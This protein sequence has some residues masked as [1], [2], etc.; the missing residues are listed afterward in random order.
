V[1]H[2]ALMGA[3]AAAAGV[4]TPAVVFAGPVGNG[5]GVLIQEW[6][7]AL[8]I[9]E[10]SIEATVR[11][12]LWDQVDTLHASGMAHGDLQPASI[13]VDRGMHVW[14]VDFS[15]AVAG[16]DEESEAADV[17][18]VRSILAAVPAPM[19]TAAST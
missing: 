16:A 8:P 2:E 9:D 14:L 5:A 1:E 7:N 15:R 18:A 19:E 6:V 10:A 11:R 13:L 17:V 3:M 12:H 4:R